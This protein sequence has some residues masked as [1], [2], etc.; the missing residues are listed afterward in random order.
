MIVYPAIDISKGEI[1]RLTK[2]E[3]SKKKVYKKNIVEQVRS[4][5]ENGVA[6][7]FNRIYN[8]RRN[9]VNVICNICKGKA[10]HKT[11]Y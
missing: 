6:V 9:S 2:G 8:H 3:F 10:G 1:V 4:F 11:S 5:Q 7:R